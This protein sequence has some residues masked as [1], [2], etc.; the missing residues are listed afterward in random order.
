VSVLAADY[1]TTHVLPCLMLMLML[2]CRVFYCQMLNASPYPN[3]R[4]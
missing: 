4:T 2:N 1:I 3:S